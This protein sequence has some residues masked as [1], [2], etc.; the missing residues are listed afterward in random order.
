MLQ[1]VIVAVTAAVALAVGWYVQNRRPAAPL[2]TSHTLPDQLDRADFDGPSTPWLVAV[3][4]S[5]SCST[6]AK[7]WQSAQFLAGDDVVV[8]N[9]EATHDRAIH[10][11]YRITAV[12]SVVIADQSGVAR[13]SFLGPPSSSDLWSGLDEARASVG[14]Q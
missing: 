12:P 11:R 6:C 8:Q 13:R 2:S 7:V 3:F 14:D 10:E 5:E 4:T 1:V 9:V